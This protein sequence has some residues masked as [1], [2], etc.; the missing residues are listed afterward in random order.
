MEGLACE[1]RSAPELAY[2]A[3]VSHASV[4]Q[5]YSYVEGQTKSSSVV[6]FVQLHDLLSIQ[7]PR[8]VCI[9][10][11]NIIINDYCCSYFGGQ[12]VKHRI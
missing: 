2:A 11:V 12:A 4:V 1:T 7:N 9:F 6:R 3:V 10:I 8:L 5:Q